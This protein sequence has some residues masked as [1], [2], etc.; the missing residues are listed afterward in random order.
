MPGFAAAVEDYPVRELPTRFDKDALSALAGSV[1]TTRLLLLGERHSIEENPRVVYTLMRKLG[2]QA[3]ALEW[4]PALGPLIDD[5]LTS[6]SLDLRSASRIPELGQLFCGDGRITAGH[7][8][9]LAQLRREGLLERLILFDDT[10]RT[11]DGPWVKRDAAMAACVLE[12]RDPGV[13]TLV[14]AGGLHTKRRPRREGSPMGAVLAGSIPG[15]PEGRVDYPRFSGL[16][17]QARFYR[18]KDG[19]FVFRLARSHS[20][21]LPSLP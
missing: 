4:E 2:F 1:R 21:V 10:P 17:T 19:V 11:F 13:R 20:A 7:F 16:Q 15:I 5:F 9:V 18:A 14:V 8:A 6:G 3:L 12:Q